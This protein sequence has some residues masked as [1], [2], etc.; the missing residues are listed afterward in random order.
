[1]IDTGKG[2]SREVLAKLFGAYAQADAATSRDHGGTGLGLNITQRLANLMGGDVAAHSEEGQGSAFTL[3][4]L[5]TVADAVHHEQDDGHASQPETDFTN[6]DLAGLRVLVVDDHPVNRIVVKMLLEPFGCVITE[7]TDGQT[8]LDH[9]AAEAVDIV[10][11]DVNMPG[12][13]GLEATRRIRAESSLRHLP[14]IGLT[15]DGMEAQ[16]TA[17]HDAGMD[18][19]VLKPID[20]AILLRVLQK[21]ARAT[22]AQGASGAGSPHSKRA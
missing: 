12:M 21:W 7:A 6:A 8:A 10:L 19:Q 22:H 13:G 16:Q 15:A 18:D 2:M 14:I 5:A 3:T 1:V 20:V 9:L 4:F 11:M 17:G